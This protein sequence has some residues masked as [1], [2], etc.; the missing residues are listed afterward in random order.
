[1]PWLLRLARRG[2]ACAL[3]LGSPD[4]MRH[5]LMSDNMPFLVLLLRP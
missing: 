1:L 2:A 4:L 3:F 5:H